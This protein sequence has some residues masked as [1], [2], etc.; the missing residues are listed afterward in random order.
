MD[1]P[2]NIVFLGLSGSGKGTQVKLLVDVLKGKQETRIIST[3]DLFRELKTK[4]TD[5]GHRVKKI[6]EEG[7]LPYDDLATMLWMY[8][9]SFTVGVNEGIIFDGAPRRLVEAKNID[10][11]FT[12]LERLDAL[13]I[14]Y[15]RVSSEEIE[16]RLLERGR[17]DDKSVAIAN[18]IAYFH[19]DVIPVIEY[20][21]NQNR[22]IEINGEQNVENIHK[23]IVKALGL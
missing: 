6:L 2:L 23:D 19:R 7:G 1:K 14:I 4:D 10:N 3:G 16:R 8:E 9:I 20:Y 11:F 12:F 22:I 21:K 13:K 15:L 5:V 17:E 18:R